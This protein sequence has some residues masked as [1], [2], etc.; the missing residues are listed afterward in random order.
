MDVQYHEWEKIYVRA[1]I[2]HHTVDMLSMRM[3]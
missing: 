3:T 1:Q 2:T